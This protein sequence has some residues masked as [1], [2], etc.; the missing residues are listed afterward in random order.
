LTPAERVLVEGRLAVQQGRFA[1][2]ERSFLEGT[3]R[4]PDDQ[5]TWWQ[6]AELYFHQNP[7]RARSPQ[8]ALAA[9]QR[10]LVI[11]PLNTEAMGHLV[12]LA[13]MRGERGLVSR[14]SDRLLPLYDEPFTTVY[15]QARAW[16]RE[17]AAERQSVLDEL[18][19][20]AGNRFLLK[21]IFGRAE[22]QMDGWADAEQV[23]RLFARTES[24]GDKSYSHF[25]LGL[26]KLLRG[27]PDAARAQIARA[28]EIYPGGDAHAAYFLPWVDILDF[29]SA[30]PARLAAA[31]AEA[32]RIEIDTPQI[33]PAKHHLIGALAARAGDFAA[34]ENAAREL[35]RMPPLLGSSVTSDLALAVR[36]RVLAAHSQPAAA[37]ALLEK[38][39]LRI[40]GRYASFYARIAENWLRAGLLEALQRPREAL[41][42]YDALT[43]YLF[44]DPIFVPVAHL[45]K[46][47]LLETLGDRD[48]AIDHYARFVELWKDCE[49]AERA[50]LER[51]RS[52]LTALRAAGPTIAEQRTKR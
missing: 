2:A 26:L 4:Y 28:A 51:A 31:R 38:Q 41:P 44:V 50:E 3:Q 47:R 23:S 48:G 30:S 9:L 34:A 5:E 17:D 42:L 1:D 36:A 33:A 27:Q 45:R 39:E 10:V 46:A 22:W 16:A 7:L 29:V 49:P 14:L 11:D 13:Q 12:D 52:R 19:A 37:L 35:E 18:R 24:A 15:R 20:S 8:E 40:P 25:T 32:E 21:L 43:F 6:L